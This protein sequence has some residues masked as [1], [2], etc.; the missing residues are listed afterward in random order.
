MAVGD[1]LNDLPMLDRRYAHHLACP[2][3]AVDAVKKQVASQGGHV[4]TAGI[5]SGVVEA[6]DRFFPQ[7]GIN[8]FYGR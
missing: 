2:A 4:C 8:R 3:N 1:H 6:W 7:K 5:A